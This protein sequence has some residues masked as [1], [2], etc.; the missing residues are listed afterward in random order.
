VICTKFHEGIDIKPIKRDRHGNPLDD[1]K[2]IA[3][4]KVVHINPTSHHSSYGKYLVLEHRWEGGPLYSLYAHL[5]SVNV[6]EGE[7]VTIGQSLGR[8]GYTGTG[9]NRDRAHLHLE[10]AVK[11]TTK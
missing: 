1:V 6:R 7:K 5:S 3:A 4:G 2:A 10:L 11:F 9:L 8:L